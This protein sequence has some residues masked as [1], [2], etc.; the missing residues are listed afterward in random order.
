MRAFQPG[1]CLRIHFY[2]GWQFFVFLLCALRLRYDWRGQ[3]FSRFPDANTDSDGHSNRNRNANWD[4]NSYSN[5]HCHGDWYTDSHSKCHCHCNADRYTG[6]QNSTYATAAASPD[7]SASPVARCMSNDRS[8]ADA[9]AGSVEMPASETV[10]IARP[11]SPIPA[12]DE[13][14]RRLKRSD[15]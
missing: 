6:P 11:G 7:S 2:T 12:T 5:C 13:Q 9:V 14:P 10:H 4:S 1:V 8:F 15:R 3:C